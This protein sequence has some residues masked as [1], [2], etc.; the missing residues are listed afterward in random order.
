MRLI[1][2]LYFYRSVLGVVA[3]IGT[4]GTSQPINTE[5]RGRL[6]VSEVVR[7]THPLI[8][9][10]HAYSVDINIILADIL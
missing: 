9:D 6:S 8:S 10:V 1:E 3:I 5:K 4:W 7:D 2:R